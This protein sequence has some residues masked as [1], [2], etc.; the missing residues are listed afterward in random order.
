MAAT[1]T[2]PLHNTHSPSDPAISQ[3]TITIAGI[4]C[5]IHGLS[6]LL[7][8]T[9]SVACLWL[10]HPR[11][12]KRETMSPIA[13]QAIHT[14]NNHHRPSSNPHQGLIAV[15]FD[16]R[17][18]GSRLV[19]ALHN[20]AWRSG[21]PRH[22][23]DMYS[24]YHGTAMDCSH[25]ISHLE[26]YIFHTPKVTITQHLCL[27]ISLGG[28]ATW[29]ALLSDPRITAGV[30]GIGCPDYTRLMTDRA[31]LSKR[32]SYTSSS[33]PGAK[34]LGSEDFPP[35]LLD[36]IALSDPA[37]LLLPACFS[38]LEPGKLSPEPDKQKLERMRELVRERL[39]GKRILNL[40]G[41]VDRLVP[42]AAGEPFLKVFKKMVED[43]PGLGI[44]FQD[45]LFEGVG[46]Q[47]PKEMADAAV[48]WLC[49]VLERGGGGAYFICV[50][51]YPTEYVPNLPIHMAPASAPTSTLRSP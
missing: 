6:E 1:T 41:K 3:T 34:F 14:W 17:N 46:H 26:S 43:D 47:F 32:E 33:P 28:H 4:L 21:N 10:L 16:Q 8:T 18:H 11:L 45:V 9:S 44:E 31:R 36:A 37:G 5:T 23:P 48:R 29:H 39:G 49:E 13:A 38:P 19:D 42:Y 27:G 30:V 51:M 20:E 12:Q 25:L 15:S 40:S 24:C 22:A 7:P 50:C 2:N 35:A